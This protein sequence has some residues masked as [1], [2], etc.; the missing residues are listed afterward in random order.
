MYAL[1]VLLVI[2]VYIT[3]GKSVIRAGR[4]HLATSHPIENAVS[5]IKMHFV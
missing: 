3:F 2:T 4:L 1:H 5:H